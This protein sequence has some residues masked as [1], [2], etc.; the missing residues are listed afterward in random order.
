MEQNKNNY[1]G[2]TLKKHGS[3]TQS[4]V[5]GRHLRRIPRYKQR[6]YLTHPVLYAAL[7]SLHLG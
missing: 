6:F 1:R 2:A 5:G 4:D 7:L 3:E